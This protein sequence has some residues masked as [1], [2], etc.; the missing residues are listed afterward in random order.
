MK[1]VDMKLS[2]KDKKELFNQ[3]TAPGGSQGPDYPW[4]LQ[5]T[6]DAEALDKLG[7]KDLPEVG[8]ECVI[9]ATAKVT[10]VSQSASERGKGH[11]SVE[12]Q[13]TKLAINHDE[14]SDK[15]FEAGYK[16]GPKRSKGY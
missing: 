13:I 16:K 5:V 14:D 12:Y 1:P 9:T 2:K 7:T 4:G 8:Q 11:R 10:R 15:A 6:L 3:V